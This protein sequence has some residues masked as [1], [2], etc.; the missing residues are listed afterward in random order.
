[1]PKRPEAPRLGTLEVGLPVSLMQDGRR[2]HGTI[3]FVTDATVLVALHDD[4]VIVKVAPE[5]LSMG[6]D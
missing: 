3:Q 1:M 6:W 5:R 4:G 2:R